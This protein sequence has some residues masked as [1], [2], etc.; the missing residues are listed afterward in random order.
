[1]FFIAIMIFS[2]YDQILFK[3]QGCFRMENNPE[4]F[5]P[6]LSKKGECGRLGQGSE[7]GSLCPSQILLS[8]EDLDVELI[9]PLEQNKYI[10]FCPCFLLSVSM[11]PARQSQPQALRFKSWCGVCKHPILKMFFQVAR[12]QFNEE[13][14][15]QTAFLGSCDNL[16][17]VGG[18]CIHTLSLLYRL[19]GQVT[20]F[21]GQGSSFFPQ[22][23]QLNHN[24]KRLR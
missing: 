24:S 1:M 14:N 18:V 19:G 13:H 23:V 7:E 16:P 9:R 2:S 20:L 17:P 10:F 11:K 22:L 21:L 4:T 3:S 6:A 5:Q 15:F 12:A 8:E